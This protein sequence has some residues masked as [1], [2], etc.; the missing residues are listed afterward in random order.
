MAPDDDVKEGSDVTEF[1]R[2]QTHVTKNL[3]SVTSVYVAEG[4]TEKGGGRKERRRR[5]RKKERQKERKKTRSNA[6]KVTG[7]IIT[8]PL[9]YFAMCT[10]ELFE[11]KLT[12]R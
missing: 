2:R 7:L 11:Q 8:G 6:R 4:K 10:S 3:K 1:A 12:C 5:R 9:P